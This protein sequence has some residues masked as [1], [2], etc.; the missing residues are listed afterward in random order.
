VS[1]RANGVL[2][3][4]ARLVELARLLE[5]L[6]ALLPR[7]S[8]GQQAGVLLH[9]E[10]TF[11]GLAGVVQT[12]RAVVE[13]PGQVS[14]GGADGSPQKFCYANNSSGDVNEE[15]SR[16]TDWHIPRLTFECAP[17]RPC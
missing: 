10:Q 5:A 4:H 15:C 3:P 12:L 1:V 6:D 7:L 17:F 11:A 14:P 2:T 9:V 16:W 13:P 8:L